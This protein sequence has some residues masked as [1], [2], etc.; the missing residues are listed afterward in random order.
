MPLSTAPSSPVAM[1]LSLWT[2]R[3]MHSGHR[4]CSTE[5]AHRLVTPSW[6]AYDASHSNGITSLRSQSR[7]CRA[8]RHS[9]GFVKLRDYSA[10]MGSLELEHKM[11]GV[12][13]LLTNGVVWQLD[14]TRH[15][16]GREAREGFRSRVGVNRGPRLR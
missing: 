14:S 8:A 9:A 1:A 4:L 13:N 11:N 10:T 5:R 6:P 16:A 3:R 15:D 2:T 7:T 12:A